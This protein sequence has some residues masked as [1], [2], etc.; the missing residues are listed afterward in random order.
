MKRFDIVII[1]ILISI[2]LG[3]LG[4]IK[5][6]NNKAYAEEYVEIS[7]DGEKIKKIPLENNETF[8]VKTELGTN[9]IK[10]ESGKVNVEDADCPDK[11]CIED[12]YIDEPG[13]I[14]VCL[15]NK[16]VIEIIGQNKSRVDDISY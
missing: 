14:L 16:V 12:G 10:V 3:S 9:V 15:P 8:T 5:Y 2:S 6:Y 7:V 11:V 4:I 1:I 13:E